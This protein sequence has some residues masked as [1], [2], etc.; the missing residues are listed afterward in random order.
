V[1]ETS[2]QI[3]EA[4]QAVVDASRHARKVFEGVEDLLNSAIDRLRDDGSVV[5]LVK[6]SN[7]STERALVQDALEELN[8]ARHRFRL[9][10]VGACIEAGMT[11]REVADWWGISRQR[12]DQFI[13]EYRRNGSG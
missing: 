12:V 8:G 3:V 10:V 9:R 2:E 1:E 5:D 11:P 7:I 13:Q 6:E 4:V